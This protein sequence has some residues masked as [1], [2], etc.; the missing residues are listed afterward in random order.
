MAKNLQSGIMS[1]FHRIGWKLKPESRKSCQPQ[2]NK[3][4]VYYKG[5]YSSSHNP[6]PKSYTPNF[7]TA[8]WRGD[9]HPGLTLMVF[10]AYERLMDVN[11]E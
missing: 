10:H 4:M 5:G 3:P 6:I 9:L 8:V 11:C 7:F 2:I 1:M